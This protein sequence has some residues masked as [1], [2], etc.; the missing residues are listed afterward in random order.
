MYSFAQRED[1]KVYDEPLYAY[2][3]R[4]SE[5]INYHPGV[6]DTLASMENDGQ[7]VI[8]WMM[9]KHDAPVVFFK[10][11][12]HHLLDLDKSFLKDC[13][14]IM[15][16]RHPRE[17][18]PSF[19]K[20][21]KQP[22][23]LDAGYGIHTEMR[24][25]LEQENIPYAVLDAGT[26]LQKPESILRQLCGF[27]SIPF[28]DNMLSWEAGARPED[29]T[30]AKYWYHQVHQSTGFAPYRPKTEPFPEYL[31]PLLEECLPHYEALSAHAFQLE[32]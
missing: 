17:M 23:L 25:Y 7:K 3:L 22:N 12:V 4:N 5:A 16:T 26:F 21:V 9:G 24:Q 18:I 1:T 20:V 6:E 14:H 13:T 10:N 19:A 29:G 15:L 28:D 32:K 2:Y 11:M 8:E 30:W 31:E 27:A